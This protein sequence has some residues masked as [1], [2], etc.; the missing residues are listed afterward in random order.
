LKKI[1][2]FIT[3][4]IYFCDMLVLIEFLQKERKRME[5]SVRPM[6]PSFW[7][8]V[9]SPGEQYTRIRENPVFWGPLIIAAVLGAVMMALQIFFAFEHPELVKEMFKVPEGQPAFSPEQM[10][11]FTIGVTAVAFL[12]TMPVSVLI[13]ALVIWVLTMLFQGEASFRQL[14]SLE[15]H[16]QVFSL[17]GLAVNLVA[18]AAFGLNPQ[19]PVTSL[20]G[21]VDAEG[22]LLG[23]LSSVELFIIWNTIVL[24]GGLQVVAG[25]SKGKAWT[26]ALLMYLFHVVMTVITHML[27]P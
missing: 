27:A 13:G 7:G 18:V 20:A 1:F 15:A 16:L 10:K 17:M 24:A 4:F 5:S 25:L 19:I 23:I 2:R 8:M 14:F 9:T 21:I 12:F 26:I 3:F 11:P 6:K 22:A